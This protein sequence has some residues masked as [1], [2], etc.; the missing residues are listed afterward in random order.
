MKATVPA[1]EG[2]GRKETVTLKRKSAIFFG[3]INISRG[4]L[5]NIYVEIISRSAAF[6]DWARL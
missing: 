6:T 1:G 2:R 5:T 4:L 3:G